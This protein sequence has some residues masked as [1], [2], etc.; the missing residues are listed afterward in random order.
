MVCALPSSALLSLTT[1][2]NTCREGD[3]RFRPRG[4]PR[5]PYSAWSQREL[6]SFVPRRVVAESKQGQSE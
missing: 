2:T 3:P 1:H 5:D 4:V 6:S